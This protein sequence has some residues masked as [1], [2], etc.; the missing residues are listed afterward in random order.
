MIVA[1][2]VLLFI[3]LCCLTKGR[4]GAESMTYRISM[5]TLRTFYFELGISF[6]HYTLRNAMEM[7][8]FNLSLGIIF[9]Q[10]EFYKHNEK[11]H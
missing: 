9:I 3:S 10:I 7:E 5:S 8:Q 4:R 1:L 6:K 11:T 2:L